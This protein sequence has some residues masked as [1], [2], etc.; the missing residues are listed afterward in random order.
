MMLKRWIRELKKSNDPER[1]LRL[2]KYWTEAVFPCYLELVGDAVYENP[3]EGLVWAR[4]SLSLAALI[5]APGRRRRLAP[6]RRS[7][8]LNGQRAISTQAE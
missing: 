6:M 8:P 7:V 4:V 2:E 1:V 3:K 5:D